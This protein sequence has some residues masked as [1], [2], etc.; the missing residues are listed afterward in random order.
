M[1]KLNQKGSVL[2]F[3]DTGFRTA[4]HLH[5]LCRRFRTSLFGESPY[6]AARG[7]SRFGRRQGAERTSRF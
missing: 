7:R 6:L 3:S 2:I 4:R 1:R 5:W